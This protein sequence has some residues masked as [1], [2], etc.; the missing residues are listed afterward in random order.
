MWDKLLDDVDFNYYR[1]DILDY[2][3]EFDQFASSSFT[4]QLSFEQL[5]TTIQHRMPAIKREQI[6]NTLETLLPAIKT[7]GWS[8][9]EFIAFVPTL[10]FIESSLDQ[11]R[12]L[13]R[14]RENSI[15]D[16]HMKRHVII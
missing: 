7:I 2:L 9:I 1:D 14:F 10:I 12:T 5:V 16:S 15:L 8:R 13:F 11:S 4:N 6:V 3:N